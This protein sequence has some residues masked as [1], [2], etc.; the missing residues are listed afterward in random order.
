MRPSVVT[1]LLRLMARYCISYLFWL[2]T[3]GIWLPI[4]QDHSPKPH[5]D[6]Q[7]AAFLAISHT[8]Q[9]ATYDCNGQGFF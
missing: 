2:A 4:V 1:Q 5:V 8:A 6:D 9:V 7:Y 3:R